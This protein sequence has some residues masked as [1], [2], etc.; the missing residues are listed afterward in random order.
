[1][2]EIKFR[3]WDGK[4][5]LQGQDLMNITLGQALTWSDRLMQFVGLHDRNGKEVFEG[6]ILRT[7]DGGFTS[8]GVQ[9][10]KGGYYVWWRY[11]NPGPTQRMDA[12]SGGYIRQ[13]QM[14]M[15]EVI[16]NIYENP[17]LLDAKQKGA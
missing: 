4:K 3:A 16:G 10:K 6:D 1:M 13:E 12:F 15:H 9:F 11:T 5:M 7:R 17:E 14:E 8:E 2:R